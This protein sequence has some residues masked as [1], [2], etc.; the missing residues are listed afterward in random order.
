MFIYLYKSNK[1]HQGKKDGLE[2]LKSVAGLMMY[3]ERQLQDGKKSSSKYTVTVFSNHISDNSFRILDRW[4]D[5][6]VNTIIEQCNLLLYTYIFE[7]MFKLKYLLFILTET[8]FSVLFVLIF[9]ATLGHYSPY[10]MDK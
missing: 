9:T 1:L 3:S 7:T 5:M 4:R 6:N 8:L 10:L 2:W